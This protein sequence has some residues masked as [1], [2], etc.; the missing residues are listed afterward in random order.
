MSPNKTIDASNILYRLRNFAVQCLKRLNNRKRENEHLPVKKRPFLTIHVR[1]LDSLMASK[2]Q[3][4]EMIKTKHKPVANTHF[5]FQSKCITRR[6]ASTAYFS[7]EH[8]YFDQHL[9]TIK[10]QT[11]V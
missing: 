7:Q 6:P 4:L 11:I 8:K 5:P 1:W 9:P 10:N 2:L 3:V